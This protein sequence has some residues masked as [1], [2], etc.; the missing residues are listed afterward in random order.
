MRRTRTKLR[1]ESCLGYPISRGKMM[2]MKLKPNQVWILT[3]H[4]K[5][6][7]VSWKKWSGG[8]LRTICQLS[9]L[10]SF[11]IHEWEWELSHFSEMNGGIDSFFRNELKMGINY[12][13][14]VNG[15]RHGVWKSQK[16]SHSTLRAKRA[17][18]TFWVDKS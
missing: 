2:S 7:T 18:F 14:F 8:C 6:V 11:S 15:L 3:K 16:K 9:S 1:S 5:S 17:T 12:F 10:P 4:T 13:F